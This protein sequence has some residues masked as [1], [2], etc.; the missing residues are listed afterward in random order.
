MACAF[1][2][3][4]AFFLWAVGCDAK[5][6][7][8]TAD[9][10]GDWI[11]GPIQTEWGPATLELRFL[12]SSNLELRW[13]PIG[14]GNEIRSNGPYRIVNHA[15]VSPIIGDQKPVECWF[16]HSYLLLKSAAPKEPAIR[17]SRKPR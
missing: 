1:V 16:E 8:A 9:L 5:R 2:W 13:I 12:R 15:I 11:S 4:A 17:F 3:I 14:A 6:R 10:V 7:I